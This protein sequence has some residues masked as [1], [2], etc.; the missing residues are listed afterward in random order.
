[1]DFT[2]YI[3]IHQKQKRICK[4][5]NSANSTTHYRYPRTFPLLPEGL[6]ISGLATTSRPRTMVPRVVGNPAQPREAPIDRADSHGQGNTAEE[7]TH[8]SPGCA[9]PTRGIREL[10]RLVALFV[11]VSPDVAGLG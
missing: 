1:M 5:L 3:Y 6:R 10:S 11:S 7:P 2:F 4:E 9:A 8:L